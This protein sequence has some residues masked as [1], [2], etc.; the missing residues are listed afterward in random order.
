MESCDLSFEVLVLEL[1]D[2]AILT[3]GFLEVLADG[4]LKSRLEHG[5]VFQ[6]F[7]DCVFLFALAHVIILETI[8]EKF[9]IKSFPLVMTRLSRLVNIIALYFGL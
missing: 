2:G 9:V 8:A 3:G 5:V 6:A 4:I 1:V 7:N